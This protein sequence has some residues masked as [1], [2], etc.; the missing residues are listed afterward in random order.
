MKAE[1]IAAGARLI[2]AEQALDAA[3]RADDLEP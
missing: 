3:F 2:E 1:A